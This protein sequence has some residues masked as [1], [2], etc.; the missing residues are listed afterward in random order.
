MDLFQSLGK[1][2][3]FHEEAHTK[4]R[5]YVEPDPGIQSPGPHHQIVLSLSQG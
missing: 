2:S 4:Q 1:T 3:H 5:E